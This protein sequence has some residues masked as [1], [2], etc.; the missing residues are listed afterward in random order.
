[1][2][3]VINPGCHSPGRLSKLAR[4]K[5]ACLLKRPRLFEILDEARQRPAIWISTP[6]GFGKTSLISSYLSQRNLEGLWYRIDE[7]D[8][9]IGHFFHYLY[10]AGEQLAYHDPELPLFTSD[11][12][13][14]LEAFARHFFQ[15]LYQRLNAPA[16]LIFDDY[17]AVAPDSP[18]H[19]VLAK[20]VEDLPEQLHVIFLSREHPP[21]AFARLRIHGAF[22]QLGADDLRFTTEEAQALAVNKESESAATNVMSQLNELL[23]GWAAGLTLLLERGNLLLPAHLPDTATMRVLFDYFSEEFFG[24]LDS[25]A[26][27]L[28]LLCA[29]FPEIPVE[30]VHQLTEGEAAMH[31]LDE[32]CRKNYFTTRHDG[33]EVVYRFHPLFRAFLLDQADKTFVDE[34]PVE[35]QKKAAHILEQCGHIEDAIALLHTCKDWQALAKIILAHAESLA[36][37]GR[38]QMLSSWIRQLPETLVEESPWLLYWLGS[39]QLPFNPTEARTALLRAYPLFEAR[40]DVAGL[41]LCWANIARSYHFAWSSREASMAWAL[42][43]DNLQAKYPDFPSRSIEIRV[44]LNLVGLLRLYGLDQSQLRHW[45][46]R[47]EDLLDAIDD[48]STRLMIATELAWCYSWLGMAPQGESLMHETAHLVN[49]ETPPLAHLNW[50]M[51]TAT[52]A[53]N[54]TDRDT[55][56]EATAAG[57]RIADESKAHVLDLYLCVQGTYGTLIVGDITAASALRRRIGRKPPPPQR[58]DVSAFHHI[59]AMVNLHL[60]NFSEATHHTQKALSHL[61]PFGVILPRFVAGICLA[62]SLMEG[63]HL[64]EADEYFESAARLTHSMDNVFMNHLV[65]LGKALLACKRGRH[66]KALELLAAATLTAKVRGGRY[67]PFYH[68]E[69]LSALYA[70]GL[71]AGLEVSCLQNQ[72]QYQRLVPTEPAGTPDNWP[73]PIKIYT[74]G[75]FSIT[76]DGAPLKTSAKASR[77]PM[78][79]LKTLIAYGGRNVHQ[80]KLIAAVWPDAEGD[81][82]RHTFETTLY[83]LRKLLG[84]ETLNVKDALLTLEPNYCWV[85]CWTF[86]RLLCYVTEGIAAGDSTTVAQLADRMLNLYQGPFLDRDHNISVTI[87]HREQLRSHLLCVLESL[88]SYWRLCGEPAR[89]CNYYLRVLEVDPSTEVFY[90]RL[91]QQYNLLGRFPEAI[92]VYQRCRQTLHSLMGVAP[93]AEINALYAETL[94]AADA[95]WL[96]PERTN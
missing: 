45:L 2:E 22:V 70:L 59:H 17:Q 44:I 11:N 15:R 12:L 84:S 43:F 75:R 91:M 6:P 41:Y 95:D 69:S 1:M 87:S 83:R 38:L 33:S 46:K 42:A 55:C 54:R 13:L 72:I 5:A 77:K 82:A 21:A 20:A 4:P 35:L 94:A 37:Q 29:L 58:M 28:L 49:S 71:E 48:G 3:E 74:L 57:L 51:L 89:T 61:E 10:K 52:Y 62:S 65:L 63:G 36:R 19:R 73:W 30:A 96:G 68:R 78:Q 66:S 76:K 86:E 90:Q 9:D 93:S 24:S 27:R 53:W 32:L 56:M 88:G 81:D 25:D 14:G 79:L 64:D 60:G 16:L 40:E 34:T 47:C 8:A 67:T 92:A 80:D 39:C 7:E 50:L 23:G 26:Q 18:L 85:D 31:L